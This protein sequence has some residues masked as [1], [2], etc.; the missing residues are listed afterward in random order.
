M[1]LKIMMNMIFFELR[2]RFNFRTPQPA[3]D[4]NRCQDNK[5][6]WSLVKLC[7]Q[8]K[9]RTNMTVGS[10]KS[11]INFAWNRIYGLL[12]SWRTL[13]WKLFSDLMVRA[14]SVLGMWAISCS[15]ELG[16]QRYVHNSI[17][18]SHTKTLFF[19]TSTKFIMRTSRSILK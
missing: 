3:E 6:F 14:I 17:F 1:M 2:K 5:K 7:T 15:M 18:H 10:H 4:S 12:A 16:T 8:W 19:K 13:T 9:Y 11:K